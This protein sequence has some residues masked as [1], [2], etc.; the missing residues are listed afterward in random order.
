MDLLKDVDEI[1]TRI[2][3]EN[4]LSRKTSYIFFRDLLDL[5]QK[6]LIL[7]GINF[8][9]SIIDGLPNTPSLRTLGN[10]SHQAC[11]GDDPR[12]TAGGGT[13]VPPELGGTG[14]DTSEANLD[15]TLLSTG[16]DTYINLAS[17]A[18][19]RYS[20]KNKT[21]DTIYQ[22]MAVATH[23]S[24]IGVTLASVNCVGLAQLTITPTLSGNIQTEGHFSLN[25]WTT[26]IGSTELTP[27]ATYFLSPPGMLTT[28]QPSTGYVQIIGCAVTLNTLALRIGPPIRL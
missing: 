16:F 27:K 13:V 25:D 19:V 7:T 24:G 1:A 9:S 8:D 18:I 22:G 2:L 14:T 21:S 28:V 12:L 3:I 20:A 5:L 10:G 26:I 15:E 11:A 23:N 4:T 6:R 17:T